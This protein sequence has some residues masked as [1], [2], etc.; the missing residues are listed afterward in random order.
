MILVET[1][2]LVALFDPRDADHKAT[3]KKLSRLSRPLVTTLPSLDSR[4]FAVY[5]ARIGRSHRA[6]RLV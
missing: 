2:P 4:H 3:V 1:G 6:F 5:R